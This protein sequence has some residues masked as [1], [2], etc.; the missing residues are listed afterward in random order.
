[1]EI[2]NGINLINMQNEKKK[3]IIV[4]IISILSFMLK[5]ENKLINIQIYFFFIQ[6]KLH[7]TRLF[8]KI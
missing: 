6:G 3:T 7:N 1:M 5:Y 2:R 4:Y 8:Q